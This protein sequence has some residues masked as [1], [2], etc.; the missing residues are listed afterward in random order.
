MLSYYP[1]KTS[2][3]LMPSGNSNHLFVIMTEPCQNNMIFML[4]ISTIYP[5]RYHDN[6]CTFCGGEHEFIKHP[7]YVDYN[8][9]SSRP[10]SL[11]VNCVRKGEFI[12]KADIDQAHFDRMCEG[13]LLSP[14]SPRWAKQHFNS[15][16]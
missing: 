16:F 7:S 4:S 3:V 9:A 8:K 15:S 6:T 1:K 14:R 11:I 10:I 13:I 5:N 12:P 2:T